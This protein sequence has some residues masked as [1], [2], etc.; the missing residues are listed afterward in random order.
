[1]NIIGNIKNKNILFLQGPMGDFFKKTDTLFREKGANT[2][3]V[4][5]NEGDHFF[6]NKDNY[7][8]YT[9]T[10]EEY[11]IFIIDFIRTN[12][13]DK[14]FLFG[15]CRFYQKVS[16]KVALVLGIDVY[17]FEEGYIRPNYITMEKYGVNNYS[18]IPREANFYKELKPSV[19]KE[20]IDTEYS[21]LKMVVSACI[22][23]F[24][25]NI[26]YYRYTN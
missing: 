5:F 12:E 4:G 2:Y 8:P 26:Y 9:G 18:H 6:S 19:I 16:V 17:V 1:M 10:R 14:I 7:I 20:A 21:Q 3:K 11:K 23:Y 25:S 15:D 24:L 22:Y 13:I